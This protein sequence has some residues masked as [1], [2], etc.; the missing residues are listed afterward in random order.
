M[1]KSKLHT[2]ITTYKSLVTVVFGL[3]IAFSYAPNTYSKDFSC[4][5]EDKVC[6]DELSKQLKNY[7]DAIK[8]RST[9]SKKFEV[10]FLIGTCKDSLVK[11]QT[12]LKIY[13]YYLNSKIMGDEAVAIHVIDKYFATGKI[14]MMNTSDYIMAKVY[15]DFNR[16]SLIGLRAPDLSLSTPDDQLVKIFPSNYGNR[17]KIMY[18]YDS[19]CLRCKAETPLLKHF[20]EK[21]DYPVDVYL[22][23]SGANKEDWKKYRDVYFN[24]NNTKSESDNIESGAVLKNTKIYHFYDPDLN[25][26]YQR[27]YGVMQVPMMYLINPGDII[28]GR[29]LETA[30]LSVMLKNIYESEHER[31]FANL[32]YGSDSSFEFYNSLFGVAD[33]LGSNGDETSKINL[34]EIASY[35]ETKTLAKSDILSYRR[36]IGDLLYWVTSRREPE[37]KKQASDFIQKYV[38]DKD[39]W[40]NEQ[41]SLMVLD[42]AIMMKGLLSK[43]AIGSH[44][45]DLKVYG[46]LSRLKDVNN[47]KETF[48]NLS[49]LKSKQTILFFYSENCG[50]CTKE[51]E[52]L[53]N[54]A[55]LKS[56]LQKYGR[57]TKILFVNVD[58]MLANYPKNSKVLFD[59]FDLSTLPYITIIDRKGIVLD[60]YI[61]LLSN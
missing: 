50:V 36:M 37:V 31:A 38:L 25:S 52:A 5:L 18:F 39:I 59:S 57:R 29:N 43:S 3:I 32:E 55:Q 21:N 45:P 34:L 46:K 4:L 58:S 16:S 14:K 44:V 24:F 2:I 49:A 1:L 15:A 53:K 56:L 48:Y 41:D 19:G 35:I 42:L 40:Q 20:L 26:D 13:S 30:A 8:Y 27:K 51:R 6:T 23:Y 17:Y 61:S 28:E 9:K 54:D 60:K 11:Q 47:F 33:S 10:D 7:L 22:I 12:A